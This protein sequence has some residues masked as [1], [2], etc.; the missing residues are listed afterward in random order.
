[1]KLAIAA[2][3]SMTDSSDKAGVLSEIAE[4]IGKI[5]NFPQAAQSLKLALTAV[6]SITNSS[7]KA[8]IL[9]TIIP[10]QTKLDRWRQAHNAVSLCPTDE[11]K[12]ESLSMI[13]TAWAEKKNPE[14]IE[15]EELTNAN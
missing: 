3:D 6:E 5:D 8:Q 12:V 10:F 11:C 15:K 1:M 9:R 14:L 7:D 13:L 4:T 2:A